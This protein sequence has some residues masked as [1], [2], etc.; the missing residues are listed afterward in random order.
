MKLERV[1]NG[2]LTPPIL[3]R[4]QFGWDLYDSIQHQVLQGRTI[5]TKLV[6]GRRM[7]FRL[8]PRNQILDFVT[9]TD[10]ED[11]E[12]IS[13]RIELPSRDVAFDGRYAVG[14]E[15]TPPKY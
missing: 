10:S 7:A 11:P 5:M 2:N 3:E 6:E 4:R 13:V 15:Y 9:I 14:F 8:P 1:D 12:S